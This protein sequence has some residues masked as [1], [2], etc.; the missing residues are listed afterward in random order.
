MLL[1]LGAPHALADTIVVDAVGGCTLSNAITAANND[2]P[3]NSCTT[4]GGD[5]VIVLPSDTTLEL[6]YTL[7]QITTNITITGNNTTVTPAAA[8][9]DIRILN[10]MGS[11]LSLSGITFTGGSTGGGNGGAG[12]TVYGGAQLYM[13]NCTV[14]G[15]T[16]GAINILDS[17]YS[18]IT[19]TIVSDNPG[20]ISNV[21][22]GGINIVSS[23]VYIGDSTISNNSTGSFFSGGGGVYMGHRGLNSYARLDLLN[24]TVSG[25]SSAQ[26]GGGL[27]HNPNSSSTALI[28]IQ[29]STI[30]GNTSIDE[31][32]GLSMNGANL[33]IR[34]STFSQN[35][36]SS[37]GGAVSNAQYLP[38][39]FNDLTIENSTF[40]GNDSGTGGNGYGG[41]LSLNGA[42][43]TLVNA[44]I[45]RNNSYSSGGGINVTSGYVTIRQSLIS[46]NNL[47]AAPSPDDGSVAVRGNQY[48]PE[49]NVQGGTVTLDAFNLFGTFGVSSVNGVALGLTD[50]ILQGDP[51]TVFEF[52]LADNGGATLTHNLVAGGQ[53]I[54]IINQALV[55]CI[56][57][58]Q[59]GRPRPFDG[60]DSGSSECDIGAVEFAPPLIF[61][62]GF[63]SGP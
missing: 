48:G 12:V 18:R 54:D 22:G 1:A 10:A 52:D 25:N 49:L 33:I 20:N 27:S 62:D 60:D 45:T 11:V 7:P 24:S 31:G 26:R 35:T 5:D 16:G 43:A 39:V 51:D 3:F 61:S 28:L 30:S 2:T 34:R 57:E 50:L 53:A 32:G 59:R 37:D 46:N 4:G 56:T 41:G 58:D 14:S 23:M 42:S 19:S 36:A 8:A 13:D 17:P 63:E 9:G 6:D 15:N 38:G 44:T 55:G 29:D 21:Y 47:V 40:S